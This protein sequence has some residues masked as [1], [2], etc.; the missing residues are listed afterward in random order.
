MTDRV[1]SFC[2]FVCFSRTSKIVLDFTNGSY[3]TFLM[4]MEKCAGP[5]V[6]TGVD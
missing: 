4:C 6:R 5:V 2:L 1:I 3:I